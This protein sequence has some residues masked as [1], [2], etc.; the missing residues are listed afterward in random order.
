MPPSSSRGH[1][2][3]RLSLSEYRAERSLLALR[4]MLPRKTRVRRDG[5]VQEIPAQ[6]MVPGDIL[7]VEAGEKVAADGRVILSAGL[8][9]DESEL[10]GQVPA[11][12]QGG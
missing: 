5:A 6:A 1:P 11:R 3:C 4:R 10:A 7:L 9:V 12:G 2:Q 8:Q